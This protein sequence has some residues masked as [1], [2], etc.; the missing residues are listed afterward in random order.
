[1]RL[2]VYK[3]NSKNTGSAAEFNIG[4]QRDKFSNFRP[5]FYVKLIKQ[6]SWD[7]SNKVGSF[8]GNVGDKE[9]SVTTKFNIFELG[10][11]LEAFKQRTP[12]SN[13]HTFKDDKTTFLLTPWDKTT[14]VKLKTSGSWKDE[15]IP[16][17]A[18]GFSVTRN[19][20]YFS[21]PLEPGEVQAL[22]QLINY[23]FKV[24]F[25]NEAKLAAAFQKKRQ[26]DQNKRSFP[27]RN[28]EKEDAQSSP[29]NELTS[30]D[31]EN[32]DIPF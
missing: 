23:F 28:S 3:A 2:Q 26:T 24:Y 1:M 11:I 7:D 18:F 19:K 6:S 27:D 20:N 17:R 5:E 29:A 22:I 10:G 12:W 32:D 21:I 15:T 31:E 8:K 13:F 30:S 4:F 14:T 25:D 9:K 16:V